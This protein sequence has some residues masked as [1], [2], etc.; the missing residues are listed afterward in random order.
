MWKLDLFW[1]TDYGPSRVTV[2]DKQVKGLNVNSAR[3]K[4]DRDKY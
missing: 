3:N 1:I 2:R 4:D